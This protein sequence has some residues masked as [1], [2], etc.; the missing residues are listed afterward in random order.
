MRNAIIIL[1][2]C[3]FGMCST[4]A[5]EYVVRLSVVD[6][7]NHEPIPARIYL[8]GSEGQPFYF[9]SSHPE[10]SAVRYEKQN[11]INSKSVEYHTTVSAHPCHVQVPDGEYV[12]TVERGKT[13]LPHSQTVQVADKDLEIVIPLKRWSRP[14][15]QGWYSGDTH[16]HR[17]IE[18]LKN[19]LLAEDL[20]VA[21]PLTNWV[22]I[23]GTPPAA[24]DKN[25]VD[26]AQTDLI[27]IDPTHVIWPRST[28]YEI[29]TV[30]QKRHTLGALFVLGH[31]QL[32]QTTVPPW[33]DVVTDVRSSEPQALFDMDK[34]DWP[35]AMLLPT[36][37]P[38]AVYELANNHVWRT[39]FAFRDWNSAA[40]AWMA[41]PFG[42]QYGGHRE[43]LDYTHS[44]YYSLLN[45][46]LRMPPSAGTANGVHPVPAG[47]GRVYVHLPDG[48]S[49]RAWMEGL[50]AGRSFVTTGPMLFATA[51][52]QD[53]GH[54]FS[55]QSKA[56]QPLV[57]RQEL[58]SVHP[59]LYGEILVNGRPEQLLRA[60]NMKT[61]RGTYQTQSE[62][63]IRPQRSGWIAV[64]WWE[65]SPDGQVRFAHS[66]PWYMEVDQQ[67]VQIAR[68]E[69]QYLMDRMSAEINRSRDVVP[70]EALEEYHQ[71]QRFYAS[72]P[73]YDDSQEVKQ[74]ARALPDNDQRKQ[75]LD[76][77]IV[78]HRFSADEVRLA[79]G[80]SLEESEREIRLRENDLVSA[81]DNQ[82]RLLPYPGGRHPRRGFLDGAL[83]PQRETKISVFAPW[84]DGGYVVVDVPEA[85]F[86]NLGLTYL[87]H[88]HVPTIW[89]NHSPLEQLEWT[90][91][92]SGLS[93]T[94]ILP[95]GIRFQTT[96]SRRADGVN[97][98]IELTNGTQD[99]LTGMRVQ[100]CTMLSG[101]AGFHLQEPLTS[102]TNVN[103]IAVRGKNPRRW[104]VTSWEPIQRVWENPPVPCIHADPIFPDCDPG[105]SVMV[106][107]SLRFYE[108]DDIRSLVPQ[109]N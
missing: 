55:L 107:G 12:L 54:V 95:N 67:P 3:F 79:T 24:G 93:M 70:P 45:C 105:Q 15:S 4:E 30:G 64:R 103:T 97:M 13:W 56:A 101:L 82:I 62:F 33:N 77:M 35:F 53:P 31:Q 40:P 2:C 90:P 26:S 27:E 109:Q 14:E 68:R 42:A 91:F 23:S 16:L 28:E 41:P 39:E 74:S 72:L 92:D 11:W 21:L 71:A 85:I 29:F 5:A 10:G 87:A 19:V 84:D 102:I 52:G 100:V 75:W 88:T 60:T 43:W 96:V 89:D 61:E 69:K 8:T 80:L 81:P 78:H 108:G 51:D 25:I 104:L 98:Q 99:R 47:F 22:T 59:L 106:S 86:S 32:L 34:L 6:A 20:N 18:E 7:E 83:N 63:R 76:N 9:Q 48:F 50:K 49:F 58:E 73:E 66:A 65:N 36:L 17:T 38:D 46:G 1:S 94:R 37:V 44:M 57:I